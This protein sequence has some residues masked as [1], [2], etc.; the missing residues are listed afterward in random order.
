MKQTSFELPPHTPWK[1]LGCFRVPAP[2][3]LS[4]HRHFLPEQVTMDDSGGEATGRRLGDGGGAGG[5]DG[6]SALLSREPSLGMIRRGNML[7]ERKPS[8]V[9]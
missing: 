6:S 1:R 3:L 4:L 9:S 5:A 7:R 8:I 2:F